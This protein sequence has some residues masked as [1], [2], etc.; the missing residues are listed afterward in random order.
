MEFRDNE[1]TIQELAEQISKDRI[2]PFYGAGISAD[3]F[4]TWGRYIESL[5]EPD[6]DET[7]DYVQE[8]MGKADYDYEGILQYIQEQYHRAFYDKTQEVFDSNK[9]NQEM[10]RPVIFEFPRLFRGPMITTN[11]DQVLEWVY[12][13]SGFPLSV[14]LA[15]ET[16][17]I[18]DRMLRSEQCLWKIHGDRDKIDSWV[19]TKEQYNALYVNGDTSFPELFQ[20]FLRYKMLL[21]IGASLKSDKI[22]QLL[23][24]LYNRDCHICHYAILQAPNDRNQFVA[25]RKRVWNLGVKPIW[26]TVKDGDYSELDR[27]IYRLTELVGSRF[28]QSYLPQGIA[29]R[30]HTTVRRDKELRKIKDKLSASCYAVLTGIDGIGKTQLALTYAYETAQEDIIFLGC[31]SRENF[32]QNL[33]DF[34]KWCG[35]MVPRTARA[36]KKDYLARFY[37]Y[38]RKRSHYLVIFDDVV[39]DEIFEYIEMLPATGKYLITTCRNNLKGFGTSVIPVSG[40]TDQEA[41]GLLKNRNPHMNVE[42]N[43]DAVIRLNRYCNGNALWLDQAASYMAETGEDIG[44][45]IDEIIYTQ[46]KSPS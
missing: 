23:A 36:V 15:G 2:I 28:N 21:F 6:D 18:H 9:I 10:L 37:E 24:E 14:G 4:P 7:R 12:Q 39:E 17:F 46:K 34:L 41:A 3:I 16:G 31:T 22:V 13:R 8:Q 38:L 44:H 43:S 30:M 11:L 40:M 26:F 27:I 35:E 5:V 1:K 25:E 42:L 32:Q 19:L 20:V 29:Y 33:C 45:Y